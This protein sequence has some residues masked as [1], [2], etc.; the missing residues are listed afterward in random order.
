MKRS[1]LS[2]DK[3]RKLAKEKL[4]K[5]RLVLEN[6]PK[7]NTLFSKEVITSVSVSPKISSSVIDS[8][9]IKT[10]QNVNEKNNTYYNDRTEIELQ[11]KTKTSIFSKDPSQWIRT[12]DFIHFVASHGVDQNMNSDFL[13]SKRIYSDQS[14]YLTK[15][16]FYRILSNNEKILRTWLVYSEIK[17]T[18]FCAPCWLFRDDSDLATTGFNDW[19]NACS[20]LKQH[21]NSINHKNCLI[22]IQD[23]NQTK[24][25]VDSRLMN[26]IDREKNYWKNILLRIVAVVKSLALRGLPF[27]G[28]NELIGSSKNGNFL[29][30]IEL[31][32]E[33]DP[34]LAQH[35]N[36]YGNAGRGSTSYLSS[37]VFEEVFIPKAGHK[38]AELFDVVN[39][40]IK[41]YGLDWSNCR[42]QS[43]DNANN[44]SGSYSGLQ[45]RVKEINNLI[46]FVPC[47][48]HSLNLVGTHAVDSS[49]EAVKY[50][51]LM[52]HL[53]TFFTISTH[54]WEILSNNLKP[55]THT[56]KHPSFTRWSSR[57]AA[58]LSINENWSE[59]IN[60]LTYI[61]NA[62]T[63]NNMTR[64]ESQGLLNKLQ[65]LET[66]FMSI[67]W[68]F[69][70]NRLNV[71]SEKLQKV[72]IDCG[73][74]VEL[75]DSLIQ[76]VTNTRENFDE[77]EKKAIEKSVTKEYKDLKTRKKIKSIFY[78]ETRH[79]DLIT[80]GREKFKIDT[81][82]VILDHLLNE[83][84][85]RR[86][87]YQNFFFSIC[88]YC[89]ARTSIT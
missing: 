34:F 44:M 22:Q 80:S 19:K 62:T 85:K 13:N 3:Y 43:Y 60:A 51:G 40:L 8:G 33:F 73:L 46:Y 2:G 24:E 81:F 64:N 11:N 54:R 10:V 32:S 66:C 59:I 50:F 82:L 75:Y 28:D 39:D 12:A 6:V 86:A 42:G 52:Q 16:M 68:G 15:S 87:A 21:E 37:T 69:L 67:L 4:E 71:V 31:I 41:R 20:R 38:S 14:R 83:L 36:K 72:E 48:A 57:D 78:D 70:L 56:L 74:V 76:L 5:Q 17:G 58:C 45:A 9:D 65:S 89:H 25:R 63:E 18:V 47:A 79:N 29:M 23:I 61:M 84:N 77:F 1:K 49:K 27:R 26:Q 7:I 30:S 35:I 53:F 88:F 55:G